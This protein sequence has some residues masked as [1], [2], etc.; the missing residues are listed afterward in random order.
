MHQS[1]LITGLDVGGHCTVIV[2]VE[3]LVAQ[4]P[5]QDRRM[6]LIPFQHSLCAVNISLTP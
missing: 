6:V 1:A 2:A 5:D 3:R 4:R